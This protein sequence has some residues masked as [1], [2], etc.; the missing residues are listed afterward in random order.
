MYTKFMYMNKGSVCECECV[1]YD[2]VHVVRCGACVVCVCLTGLGGMEEGGE[3]EVLRTAANS[4][5][6]RPGSHPMLCRRG[7]NKT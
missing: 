7:E 2:V 1:W 3:E 5:R 4:C 6:W